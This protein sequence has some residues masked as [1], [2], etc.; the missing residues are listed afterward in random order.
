MTTGATNKVRS[1]TKLIIITLMIAHNTTTRSAPPNGMECWPM[2]D[3]TC[4][5]NYS[6]KYR[7]FVLL[8][9]DT[10]NINS[11]GPC[12]GSISGTETIATILPYRGG[13]TINT[14]GGST[15]SDKTAYSGF[16][17]HATSAMQY[18]PAYCCQ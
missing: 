2:M 8:N 10:C 4:P 17:T 9:I 13:R 11:D 12:N 6:I 16:A 7:R 14:P 15:R 3:S 18:V 5:A 1:S